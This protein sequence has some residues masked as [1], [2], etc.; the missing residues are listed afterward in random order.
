MTRDMAAAQTLHTGR[1]RTP[2]TEVRPEPVW[3][4]TVSAEVST[5]LGLVDALP[6][7]EHA[8]AAN[9]TSFSVHGK[10][11]CYLWPRTRTVGLKQTL[12]EQIALVSERP[13]VFEVQFTAGGFG[14]VV[15]YLEKIDVDEL[16]ELVFE[17]WRLSAPQAILVDYPGPP[18]VL[19][20]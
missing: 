20:E 9:Y 6:G 11:F 13:D 19:G 16:S 5:F 3:Y 14:W 1:G 18:S 2:V 17:A 10:R 8:D 7:V 12:A 4:F 15:A